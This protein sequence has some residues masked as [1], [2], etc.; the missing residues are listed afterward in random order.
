MSDDRVTDAEL[1]VSPVVSAIENLAS[2]KA[3]EHDLERLAGP[4][5]DDLKAA[6]D[7][8]SSALPHDFGL[9]MRALTAAARLLW[10]TLEAKRMEQ[11]KEEGRR[12]DCH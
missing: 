3:H 6:V 1:R 5:D 2:G 12:D 7:V 11:L 9:T 4:D 8:M 10:K